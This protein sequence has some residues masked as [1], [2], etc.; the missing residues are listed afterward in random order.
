MARSLLNKRQGSVLLWWSLAT[1]KKELGGG[2]DQRLARI[3]KTDG[4]DRRIQILAEHRRRCFVVQLFLI[5]RAENR[6]FKGP[7]RRSSVDDPTVRRHRS[8][9]PAPQTHER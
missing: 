1:P 6:A 8:Q 2:D 3:R 9:S 4:S 5:G 7:V